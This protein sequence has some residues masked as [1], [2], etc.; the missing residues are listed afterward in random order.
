MGLLRR[1]ESFNFLTEQRWQGFIHPHTLIA[2]LWTLTQ[3]RDG[4]DTGGGPRFCGDTSLY[5][6]WGPL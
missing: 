3:E 1:N 4:A 6:F 5:N 2:G